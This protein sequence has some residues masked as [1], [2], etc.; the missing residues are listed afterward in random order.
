MRRLVV[1][2]GL[3]VL[4]VLARGALAAETQAPPQNRSVRFYG[5]GPRVGFS[6][7][8]DQ[9]TFG[10]HG[11]FGDPFPHFNWLLPVVE[12]GIGDSQTMTSIGSDLLYRLYDRWGV[13][14]PYL[15]GEID[16]LI[17]SVDKP[18]GGNDTST[19]LGLMGIVGME[20]GIGD[21]RF[22]LEAKFQLAD[23]PDFKVAAIWTFGH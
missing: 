13:W 17:N 22:A 18:G 20:K 15:G 2:G 4:A 14:T 23:S 1:L 5:L 9:F 19:D 11:D 16:F 3:V 21:N 10:G 6:I 7:N 12:I 8:P